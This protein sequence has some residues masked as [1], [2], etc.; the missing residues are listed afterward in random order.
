MPNTGPLHGGAGVLTALRTINFLPS[1][2]SPLPASQ[3]KDPEAWGVGL[4]LLY[5]VFYTSV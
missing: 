3:R 4:Y 2:S 1:P 5:L